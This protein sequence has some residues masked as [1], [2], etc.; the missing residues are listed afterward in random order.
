MS[1]APTSRRG[2]H[3]FDRRHRFTGKRRAVRWIAR[4]EGRVMGAECWVSGS[5]VNMV[6]WFVE[7]GIEEFYGG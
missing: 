6:R 3:R 1:L 7:S 5:V 2:E 4:A